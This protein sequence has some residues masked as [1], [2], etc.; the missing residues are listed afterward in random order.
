MVMPQRPTFPLAYST[1]V[2]QDFRSFNDELRVQ[3]MTV[4]HR[5][6]GG[7]LLGSPLAT[8]GDQTLAG[9]RSVRFDSPLGREQGHGSGT[10]VY[11][12]HPKTAEFGHPTLH[13]VAATADIKSSSSLETLRGAVAERLAPANGSL[14]L[15]FS[16]GVDA[17]FRKLKESPGRPEAVR[18]TIRGL[19]RVQEGRDVFAGEELYQ[20]SGVDLRGCKQLPFNVSNGAKTSP[21]GVIYRL[22]P[23]PHGSRVNAV[24]I[25][26]IGERD[27]AATYQLAAARLGRMSPQQIA[28]VQAGQQQQAPRST[29]TS[30]RKVHDQQHTIGLN[31][32]P[33]IA[34]HQ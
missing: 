13:V 21:L 30:Q 33:G 14:P 31:Q 15:V 6:K 29:T 2:A 1:G 24:H 20:S 28:A 34:P 9:C 22:L 11:Q 26:S 32:T 4:I 27:A 7:A 16:P 23:P 5:I 8:F 17:D 10:M 19:T 18:Q 12:L 25:V 3:A